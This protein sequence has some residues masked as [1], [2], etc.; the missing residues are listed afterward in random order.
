MRQFSKFSMI[1]VPRGLLPQGCV[2]VAG[3][4]GAV[5]GDVLFATGSPQITLTTKGMFPQGPF[6]TATL[7][8]GTWSH[9][10]ASTPDAPLRVFVRHGT[11]N[12]IVIGLVAMQ[13]VDV[14]YDLSAG[15]MGFA[16][17]E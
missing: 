17:A 11:E 13:S 1:N 10:F 4:P 16:S 5:C 2:R 7:A 15:R 14:Y 9:T 8:I 6:S 3:V 12:S